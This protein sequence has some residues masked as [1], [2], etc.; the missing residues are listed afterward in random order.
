MYIFMSLTSIGLLAYSKLS[1]FFMYTFRNY[2]LER[3][4]HHENTKIDQN[5]F[6]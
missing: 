5:F 2:F 6:F 4:L 1:K 3:T